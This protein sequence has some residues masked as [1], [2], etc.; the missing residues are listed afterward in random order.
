MR[1]IGV[2]NDEPSTPINPSCPVELGTGGWYVNNATGQEQQSE[3]NAVDAHGDEIF[4]TTNVQEGSSGC[5]VGHHQQLFVRLGGSRTLEVLRSL[6][7]GSYG[8]CVA[9]GVPGEVPCEGAL[10]RASAYFKGASEDGSKVFFTTSAPLVNGD[11]D[12]GNDL[13]MASVGCPVSELGCEAG[14]REV[15][16]LVQ[17]S[18][19]PV[20][21]QAAEVQGVVNIARD[22]SHVYFVAR[23]VLTGEGPTGEG[24][25]SQPVGGADNL[26]VYDSVSGKTVFVADLCSGPGRSGAVGDVRCPRDLQE[27]ESKANDKTLLWEKLS[28]AQS[29]PDG[30]FLVF[31]TYG[32]LVGGDTDTAKDVYRYDAQTGALERVSVGEDDYDA[33]GNNNEFDANI[34]HGAMGLAEGL[35][36]FQQEM[37]TRAVSEDGSRIVFSTAEPL[38]PDATNGKVNIYEW[39]E[40]TVSLIS[41]GTSEENDEHAMITT[42]GRDVF[43][44]TSQGLVRQ[45]TDGLSDF[46]DA[47]LG[48]GFAAVP[49]PAEPCEG[50]ACQGPLTNPAP[51]L[52]PG[53][54]SQAPGGNFAEPVPAVKVKP[55]RRLRSAQA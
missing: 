52:V 43:F 2:K 17:V 41:S 53:S 12:A 19:D 49:A 46:Y 13:Y 27:G 50:D 29:T 37:A 25:Q 55:R 39:H 22:G 28:E 48:G 47:R 34:E 16:G 21:S 44:T 33:N 54:V 18:H 20:A 30:G 7:G 23:G 31:A 24:A 51:L 35:V 40:G 3:V 32:Q 36:D 38:S 6:E 9:G 10:T 15:T 4:F 14:K 1:L 26:Y 8:G 42:S 5:A 45:D 11:E